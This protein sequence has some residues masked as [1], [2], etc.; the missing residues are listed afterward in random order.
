MIYGIVG[1]PGGGKSYE[2]VVYH[3]IPAL[4]K[5][6]KVITNLPLNVELLVKTFG[7]EVRDLVVVVDGQL[8]NFGS[9]ERPFSSINDYSDE[10]RN[11]KGQ[12][13][14]YVVDEA[15]M[16][17]PTRG[18]N[19]PILE[20]YSMH[21]HHGI[22]IVLITQNLRKL[23]RDIKDMIELTY[24][25]QKN[26]ALGSPNTYTQKVRTGA[27]GETVNTSQ[28]KYKSNYFK[29]Y[30]SHTAS[31]DT[32]KEAHAGDVKSIWRS[33]PVVGSAI[34]ILLGIGILVNL[35]F[36]YQSKHDPLPVVEIPAAVDDVLDGEDYVLEP[37]SN[38]PLATKPH[39]EKDKFNPNYSISNN[40]DLYGSLG[41]LD[42]YDFYATGSMHQ[43]EYTRIGNTLSSNSD[44]VLNIVYFDVYLNSRFMFKTT[45]TDLSALGYSV[46]ELTECVYSLIYNEYRRVVTCAPELDEVDDSSPDAAEPINSIV[47]MN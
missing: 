27:G 25:C 18:C 46:S 35:Y 7:E 19:V 23:N 10:W 36:D 41:P 3:I 42:N 28:R 9:N 13:A 30:Q 44:S 24:S 6:R 26:T 11:D 12:A 39:S 16:V 4:S 43:V 40:A 34:F 31:N 2:A 37:A 5:G 8:T 21:R 47:A 29:Y 33:W 17:L 1:K 32:V 38:L 20:W 14:L 22:D 15:H 45:N